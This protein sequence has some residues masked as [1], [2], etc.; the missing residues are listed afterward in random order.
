LPVE[1]WGIS[2]PFIEII[3]CIMNYDHIT[4]STRSRTEE[5]PGAMM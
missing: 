4:A 2:S 3:P 1:V 5:V